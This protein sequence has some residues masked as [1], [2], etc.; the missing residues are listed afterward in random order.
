M[1]FHARGAVLLP[2]AC[3]GAP[4]PCPRTHLPARPTPSPPAQAHE[5]PLRSIVCTPTPHPQA[6]ARPSYLLTCG[7]SPATPLKGP[8]APAALY[9]VHPQRQLSADGGRCRGAEDIQAQ[10]AGAWDSL[11]WW[12]FAPAPGPWESASAALARAPQRAC[13][14]SNTPPPP[15]AP[16]PLREIAAHR[17]ALRAVSVGPTDLK[18]ATASDD[19]GVKVWDMYSCEAEATLT[20]GCMEAERVEGDRAAGRVEGVGHAQLRGR[21]GADR[22]VHGS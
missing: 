10:P 16:Q 3:L 14:V 9:C 18:F 4:P 6:T 1:A 17:E 15:P 8:R 13:L 11:V 19:G 20:G 12:C 21:G 2:P 22:W 5:R 7:P